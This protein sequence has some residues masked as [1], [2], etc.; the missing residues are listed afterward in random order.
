MREKTVTGSWLAGMQ[1]SLS[2]ELAETDLKEKT[3]PGTKEEEDELSI[4]KASLAQREAACLRIEGENFILKAQVEHLQQKAQD[5]TKEVQSCQAYLAQAQQLLECVANG[6][7]LHRTDVE[8]VRAT[9]AAARRSAK[10]ALQGK[11]RSHPQMHNVAA[12]PGE[13]SLQ[14]KGGNAS[15]LSPRADRSSGG[16][17]KDRRSPGRVAR[18]NSAGTGGTG[19]SEAE[20]HVNLPPSPSMVS[21]RQGPAKDLAWSKAS[22]EH[23][24]KAE[25][26]SEPRQV[27]QTSDL[28][29]QFL[30]QRA[31]LVAALKKGSQAEEKMITMKDD[32]TRKDV[33]IHN[34]KHDQLALQQELQNQQQL[35]ESQFQLIQQQHQAQ[36]LQQVKQYQDL[37]AL[38]HAHMQSRA[39]EPEEPLVP[40]LLEGVPCTWNMEAMPV[41]SSPET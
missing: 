3:H 33:I 21:P 27:L 10:R 4:L 19:S 23:S 18:A 7:M 1:G 11:G 36:Q 8:P 40:E 31:L 30:R 2:R 39:P 41:L 28:K 35:F 29:T 14:A 24:S 22:D 17:S 37:E 16:N 38:L 5:A 25:L 20:V 9:I 12:L 34:L 32:L 6:R 15:K 26:D 13:A